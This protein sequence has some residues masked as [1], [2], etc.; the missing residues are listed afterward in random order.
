ML[1]QTDIFEG[2]VKERLQ[3]VK[4]GGN[5]EYPNRST[6]RRRWTEG[7]RGTRRKERSRYVSRG[8]GGKS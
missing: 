7:S 8:S 2:L 4:S 1:R 5:R 3:G 6:N